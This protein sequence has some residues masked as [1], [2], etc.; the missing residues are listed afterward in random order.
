MKLLV[1]VLLMCL[2][3]AGTVSAVSINPA[4]VGSAAKT[5]TPVPTHAQLTRIPA[6]VLTG[7]MVTQG[8]G[9]GM[10][11]VYSVPSGAGV[12]LDG[13]NTSGEKTPIKYSLPAG[14]HSV[15]IYMDGYQLY[16]ETFTLD[17]GAIKD[18]N[19]DLKQ[20]LPASALPGVVATQAQKI[21]ASSLQGVLVSEADWITVNLDSVPSNATVTDLYNDTYIGTT[22]LRLHV[23]PDMH[24]VKLTH[25]LY[26]WAGVRFNQS[27]DIVVTLVR[28]DTGPVTGQKVEPP[29][30]LTW[31][32]G[33]AP[34]NPAL[35]AGNFTS[36]VTL[37]TT[38]LQTVPC[39]DD[40]SCLTPAEAKQKFGLYA[41]YGTTPCG[42]EDNPGSS[43]GMSTLKYCCRDATLGTL[44]QGALAASGI[45]E[46]DDIYIINDTWIEHAV[47]K[48]SPGDGK[49]GEANTNPFQS[50]LDFL[51]GIVSGSAKPESR[52]EIVGFNPCPEPPGAPIPDPMRLK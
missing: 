44:P 42:L 25:P 26:N 11:E 29:G 34:A 45:K 3:V 16:T 43:W 10:L 12:N 51:S 33:V 2:L 19:A 48:K 39:P 18:I 38:A 5:V 4:S 40:W 9:R 15:V 31:N 50:F 46:G 49:T 22:P 17:A 8:V 30:G 37:P 13:A 20:K 47:V 41:R 35:R 6:S 14:S 27:G 21:P 7:V 32:S 24:Y 28:T 23:S 52:L 1:A 36:F